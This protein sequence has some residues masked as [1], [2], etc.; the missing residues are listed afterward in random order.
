MNGKTAG[1]G[2]S[3]RVGNAGKKTMDLGGDRFQMARK[4]LVT[5]CG[6]QSDQKPVA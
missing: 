5:P 3:V 1:K 6:L 4:P 2:G